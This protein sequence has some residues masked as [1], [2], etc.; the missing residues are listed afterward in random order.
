MKN[1]NLLK[2]AT[3]LA[4]YVSSLAPEYASL[5]SGPVFLGI[6]LLAIGVV[7]LYG[8]QQNRKIAVTGAE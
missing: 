4:N 1:D 6:L 5:A 7:L 3:F 8:I 2:A